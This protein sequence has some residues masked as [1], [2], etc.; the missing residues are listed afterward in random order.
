MP[1]PA[2]S[3]TAFLG[4]AKGRHVEFSQYSQ[5]LSALRE[6]HG[7]VSSLQALISGDLLTGLFY[8]IVDRHEKAIQSVLWATAH[9][10]NM[11]LR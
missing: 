8:L 3:H 10:Q 7:V 11:Y 2:A 5:K 6:S 1:T 9:P 4:S